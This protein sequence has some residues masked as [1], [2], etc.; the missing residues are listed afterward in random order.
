MYPPSR[1]KAI[2]ARVRIQYTDRVKPHRA[3]RGGREGT[4]EDAEDAPLRVLSSFLRVLRVI[5]RFF[6]PLI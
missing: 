5:R 1:A 2:R 6:P 3:F 4:N